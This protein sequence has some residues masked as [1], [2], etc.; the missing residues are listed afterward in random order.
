MFAAAVELMGVAER[1]RR[2]ATTARRR[3]AAGGRGLLA[4]A[5]VANATL[6]AALTTS[7]YKERP[8]R[9][10]HPACRHRRVAQRA[11]R[12]ARRRAPEQHAADSAASVAHAVM[13]G[14][15]EFATTEATSAV[16]PT[17]RSAVRTRASAAGANT[18]SESASAAVEEL[19]QR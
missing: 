4:D 13:T 5:T 12:R 17:A 7:R 8:R 3:A 1:T 6:A 9:T 18:A 2:V 10:C 19:R 15:S 14:D 11:A 16:E